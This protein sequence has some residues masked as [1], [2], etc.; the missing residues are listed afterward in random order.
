MPV[1]LVTNYLTPYRVPLYERLAERH[2]VDVWCFA[3]G[4]RYVPAWF[5]DLDDQFDRARFRTR[6]LGGPVSAIALGRGYDAV[7]APLAGGAMLP[8]AYAGAR[9]HRKGFI[10]W[11]SVWAQPRSAAHAVALPAIRHIYRHADAVVAYGEHTRRFVAGIRG[12]DDDVFVAPQSV[13]PELFARE[14]TAEETDAFRERHGLSG[15]LAL[16]AGRLVPEKGVAVLLDAWRTVESDVTLVVVGDGP[17]AQAVSTAP[18]TRL[19]GPLPRPELPAAYAASEFAL[20]PS[21]PTRRFLEPWGLV[22]N[23]AMHQGRPV[24]AS[25]AVGAVAGGL[26]RHR[27]NGLVVPPGDSGA[28]REA[29]DGLA[30]D[31][32]L[33]GRLGAAARASVADYN[34]DAMV[35]AFDRALAIAA[36][37]SNRTRR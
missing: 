13:E 35:D 36:P 23:E 16:Y 15:P 37:A 31:P 11:A 5:A 9:A 27:H 6:R 25:T 30:S 32:A 24:I 22:C 12:H 21:V 8:A 1:A 20:L 19:L 3:G 10:L 2:G 4:D 7:I 17:L 18:R 29:I 28:L 33:R 34:Y 26:V 14:V